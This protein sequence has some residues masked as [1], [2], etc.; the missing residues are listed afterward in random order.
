MHYFIESIFVGIYCV[1]LY[2]FLYL[3]NI[4]LQIKNNYI[5]LFMLGFL[6]HISGFILGIHQYYCN[7]GYQCT[8][9]LQINEINKDNYHAKY[10]PVI[11]Q[12]ILEGLYFLLLG[13]VGFTYL[14]SLKSHILYIFVLGIITHIV[15]EWLYIHNY[16][17]KTNCIKIV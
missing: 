13:S 17:C 9:V 2:N 10:K 15:S 16:F 1:I 14:S 5:L 4:T 3:L 7:F 12:S 11:Y 6:K 8:K